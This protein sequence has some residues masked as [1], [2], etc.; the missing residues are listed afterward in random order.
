MNVE[1]KI[2]KELP[3][4]EINKLEDRVVYN[5]AI[6]TREYT[7]TA[8][9]YPYLTGNLRRSEVSSGITGSNKNYGLV[10]GTKYAK[11]VYNYTNVNWTNKSTQPQWYYSVFR[12]QGNAILQNAVGRAIKEI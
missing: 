11:A 3:T 1:I 2:V 4:K 10:A 5:T 9:A 6:L 12:R 8:N 7:K